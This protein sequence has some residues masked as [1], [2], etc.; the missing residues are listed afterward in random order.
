M[1]LVRG[2]RVRGTGVDF[3]HLHPDADCAICAYLTARLARGA[4]AGL[5]RR[6]VRNPRPGGYRRRA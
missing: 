4:Y 3:P 5:R 1:R 6:S 2:C